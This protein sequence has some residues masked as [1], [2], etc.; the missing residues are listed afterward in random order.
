MSLLCPNRHGVLQSY[1]TLR[2]RRGREAPA[3]LCPENLPILGLKYGNSDTP[4][5][6]PVGPE[7]P[8]GQI[9]SVRSDANYKHCRQELCPQN[10]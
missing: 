3:K 10:V 5:D 9:S 1:S 7:V 6:G 8:V 2:S 4:F